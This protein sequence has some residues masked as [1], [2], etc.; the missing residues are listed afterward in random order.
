MKYMIVALS[1]LLTSLSAQDERAQV[2]SRPLPFE[3]QR[4]FQISVLEQ[5]KNHYALPQLPPKVFPLGYHY[6][7]QVSG[8]GD[9]CEIEDGSEWQID[10]TSYKTVLK[11]QASDPLYITQNTNWFLYMSYKYKIVNYNTNESVYANINLGPQIKNPHTTYVTSIDRELNIATLSN[12]TRWQV[13]P[14]DNYL[15]TEWMEGDVIIVGQNF[16]AT[17]SNF[18]LINV[19]SGNFVKANIKK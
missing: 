2:C 17:T 12:N 19:P 7:K 10:T 3:K 9:K 4:Q 11:W 14:A 1:L 13:E 15:I 6:L 18:I 16:R 5:Q 8:I